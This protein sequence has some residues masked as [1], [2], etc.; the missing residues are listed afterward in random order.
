MWKNKNIFYGESHGNWN[1][2]ES[3]YREIMFRNNIPLKCSD[4]GLK[5]KRVLLVHHKDKN[6]KNNKIEN[7]RWLC[8]NCHYLAHNGKTF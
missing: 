6:R 1:G 2:G 3:S 8:R 5:E 7:L 4:C